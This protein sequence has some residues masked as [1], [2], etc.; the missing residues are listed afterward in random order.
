MPGPTL[1]QSDSYTPKLPTRQTFNAGTY[2]TF[3]ITSGTWAAGDTY[4]NNGQTF[5]AL[6]ANNS[7]FSNIF[8]ASATGAPAASGTL[9][10]SAGSGSATIAFTS[11]VATGTYLLPQNPQP[12]YITVTSVGGGGGG[13]GSG[14][15]TTGGTGGTGGN[16]QFSSGTT[17]VQGNGGAGGATFDVGLAG[18]GGSASIGSAVIGTSIG[19]GAGQSASGAGSIN[20]VQPASGAGGC[21]PLGGGGLGGTSGGGSAGRGFGGGGGGGG[22][23]PIV[24]QS[25]ANGGGAGGVAIGRIAGSASL[26]YSFT[27]GAAGTAG[28]AGTSGNVGFAG[29][30]G[31]IIVDEYYQ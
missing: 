7:T 6:Y 4:T 1:F 13:G 29:A 15:T 9:T 31:I 14:T 8:T 3:V 25:P 27:V 5:T 22:M 23:T 20:T 24:N 21:C 26:N 16:S 30:A 10:R 17:L 2:Y 19:G 18:I 28:T 12:L 11:N